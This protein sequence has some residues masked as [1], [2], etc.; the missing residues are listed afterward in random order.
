VLDT[1]SHMSA[2]MTRKYLQR[3]AMAGIIIGIFYGMFVRSWSGSARSRTGR[4]SRRCSSPSTTCSPYV[5]GGAAGVLDLF[6]RALL[7]NF[8]INLAMLLVYHGLIKDDLT[9][10]LVMVM[11]VSVSVSAFVSVF[12]FVFSGFEHSV[13][14]T[15][16]FEIV[17]QQ[18]G[19]DVAAAAA[20]V[21]VALLGNLV[22]GGL[23]I[24]IYYAYVNDDA[25][26]LRRPPAPRRAGEGVPT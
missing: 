8:M 16:L 6:V 15:V 9:K 11:S 1:K 21:G 4:C 3:A 25:A 10:S 17:G 7:C 13:A 5:D 18:S 20:D 23:L 12:V 22:G 19:I 2:R 24:G 26:Y 14:N